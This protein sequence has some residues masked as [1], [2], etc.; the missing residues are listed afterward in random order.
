MFGL[1]GQKKKKPVDEFVFELEK[2]LKDPVKHKEI[3]ERIEARLQKIKELLRVGVDQ[4]Q[5]NRLGM[6]L[7]GYTSLIKVM[8][9]VTAKKK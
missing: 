2:E 7:N 8:A 4:E 9:R 5:V 6:V 3:Q 1:E